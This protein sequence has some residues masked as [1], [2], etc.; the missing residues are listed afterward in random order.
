M[1]KTLIS[2]SLLECEDEIV[3]GTEAWLDDKV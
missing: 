2:K 3:N 1:W